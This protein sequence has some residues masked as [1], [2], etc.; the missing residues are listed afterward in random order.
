LCEEALGEM[1]LHPWEFYEYELSEYL[2]R[3]KGLFRRR[4]DDYQ[5]LLIA[6]ML[7]YMKKDERV[8]IV[9][10]AFRKDGVKALSL[11]DRYAELQKRYEP[12]LAETVTRKTKAVSKNEQ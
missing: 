8:R 9:N 4:K 5:Q 3:R 6:S 1:G 7:P 11:R 12:L 10:D 2:Q